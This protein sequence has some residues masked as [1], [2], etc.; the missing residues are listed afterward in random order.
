[1]ASGTIKKKTSTHEYT[2]EQ[3]EEFR[4]CILDPI[5]FMRNYLYIQHPKHGRVKFDLYEYQER[6]VREIHEH[7]DNIILTARQQGKCISPN[8]RVTVRQSSPQGLLKSLIFKAF[9]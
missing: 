2:P 5:Y 6:M 8:T 7:K 9:S 1:M 3:L 4:R